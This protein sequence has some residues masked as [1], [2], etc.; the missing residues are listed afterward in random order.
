MTGIYCSAIIEGAVTTASPT[1]SVV[2]LAANTGRQYLLIHNTHPTAEI[3]VRFGATATNAAP[4][5]RLSAGS[6]LIFGDGSFV[7]SQSVNIYSTGTPTFTI[8]HA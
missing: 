7:P 8:W 1:T 4:A 3:W 2:A 6:S 5:F